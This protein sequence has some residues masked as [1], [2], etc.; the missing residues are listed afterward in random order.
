MLHPFVA[1]SAGLAEMLN[2]S[3]TYRSRQ[4]IPFATNRL[5]QRHIE[6]VALVRRNMSLLLCRRGGNGEKAALTESNV[7]F[8]RI[9]IKR[10]IE[11][12]VL[13]RAQEVGSRGGH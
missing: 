2:V 6:E 5:N 9:K 3:A 1:I 8:T 13:K 10:S 7:Q 4:G 11:L 12:V